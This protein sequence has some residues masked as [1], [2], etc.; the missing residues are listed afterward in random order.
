ME[1]EEHDGTWCMRALKLVKLVKLCQALSKILIQ[2]EGSAGRRMAP[3]GGEPK[4][5]AGPTAAQQLPGKNR[6]TRDRDV[7]R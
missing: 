3:Q 5:F 1:E 4:C 6:M 2:V 7:G